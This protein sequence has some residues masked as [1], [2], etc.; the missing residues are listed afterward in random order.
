MVMVQY[1]KELADTGIKVN[2]AD[3]RVHRDLN[4]N[5]GPQTVEEGARP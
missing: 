2:A 5:R 4:G 3:P 1:A